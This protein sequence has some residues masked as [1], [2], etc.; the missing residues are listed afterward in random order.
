[1]AEQLPQM[2]DKLTIVYPIE[3]NNNYIIPPF[4]KFPKIR[5]WS[6]NRGFFSENKTMVLS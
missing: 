4:R 1:M 2:A 3:L 6:Y 5:Q